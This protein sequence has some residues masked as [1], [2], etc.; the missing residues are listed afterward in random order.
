MEK[1]LL[2]PWFGAH[3]ITEIEEGGSYRWTDSIEGAQGIFFW[4]P[5]GHGKGEYPIEG[6]RPHGVLLPFKNPRNAP[7]PPDSFNLQSDGRTPRWT[8]TGNGLE[9]LT[10]TPSVA[11]GK[12]ECWHGYITGG[13]VLP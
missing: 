3:F 10:L 13:G 6:G 7:V 8:M 9:D 4:C 1:R 12:P 5:C 2:D 11:I